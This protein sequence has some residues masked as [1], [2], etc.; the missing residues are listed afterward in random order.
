MDTTFETSH[1]AVGEKT[2]S[3]INNVK[4]K[5]ADKRESYDAMVRQSPEKAVLTA[6]AEG[7]VIHLLPIRGLV[8]V[9]LRLALFL[10]KPALLAL[11][12]VKAC[13]IVQDQTRK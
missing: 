1:D 2:G 4:A 10:A 12:A 7:Y 5:A 6:L 13:E 11:G 9:P 8:A 3:V